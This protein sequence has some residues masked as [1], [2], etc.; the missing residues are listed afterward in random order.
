MSIYNKIYTLNKIRRKVGNYNAV[1]LKNCCL[2]TAEKK[3]CYQLYVFVFLIIFNRFFTAVQQGSMTDN[4]QS[5]V[6]NIERWSNCLYKG[7]SV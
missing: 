7:Y 2:F 6:C 5:K 4:V 3:F 1:I